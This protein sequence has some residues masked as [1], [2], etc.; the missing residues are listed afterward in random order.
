MDTLN[1]TDA[2]GVRCPNGQWRDER[3]K[4]GQGPSNPAAGGDGSPQVLPLL[5]SFRERA[6]GLLPP[7]PGGDPLTGLSSVAGAKMGTRLRTAMASASLGRASNSAT[8][9]LT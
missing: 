5:G 4:Y 9:P 7:P 3:A 6:G 8:S 1:Q 2:G